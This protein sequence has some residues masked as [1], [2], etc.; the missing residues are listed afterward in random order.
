MEINR[1][2]HLISETKNHEEKVRLMNQILK[3]EA[4]Q[5]DIREGRELRL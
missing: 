3:L 1:L 2:T 5:R 4:K